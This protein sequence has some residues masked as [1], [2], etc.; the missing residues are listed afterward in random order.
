MEIK[1]KV[2]RVAPVK[3][4]A[5]KFLQ[6]DK[7]KAF[8]RDLEEKLRESMVRNHFVETFK[9]WQSGKDLY[10]LDG[11]HRCLVLKSLEE[12]GYTV[13][14][15]LT[16]EFIDC[17]N[18]VEAAR[19]VLVY[20]SAYTTI[21]KAALTE[22]VT[23]NDL[24]VDDL[25]EQLNLIFSKAMEEQEE[26]EDGDSEMPEYPITPKFSENYSYVVIFTKNEIDFAHLSQTL[27][28][29]TESSYKNVA[30][31]VGRVI[32]FEKFMGLWKSRS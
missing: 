4:K 20:S 27:K 29:Q 24:N 18:K 23:V 16:G 12:R 31:G 15:E 25:T 9:V 5:L 7:L 1:N 13:P 3:W 2:L 32:P 6:T 22:F 11:F 21:N 10:C 14:E 8:P 26:D 17:K 30:T 19:L 28:L